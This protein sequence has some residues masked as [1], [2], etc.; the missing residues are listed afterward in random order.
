MPFVLGLVHADAWFS[1]RIKLGH[2]NAN[3]WI[4]GRRALV[5]Q[6]LHKCARLCK[7]FP[8]TELHSLQFC[9]RNQLQ[10]MHLLQDLLALSNLSFR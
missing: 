7:P 6:T 5:R 1:F 3:E 2:H 9:V 10:L 4:E 8:H